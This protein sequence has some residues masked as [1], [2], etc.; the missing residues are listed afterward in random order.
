MAMGGDIIPENELSDHTQCRLGKW[1]Y[2]AKG[3]AY[4]HS[5]AFRQ[6]EGPHAKIHTLGKEIAALA[7]QGQ[8]AAACQK[9]EQMDEYSQQLSCQIDKLLSEA[10]SS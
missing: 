5:D 2:S 8:T 3:E 6:M 1:Y 4:S 10:N 9:I 7:L